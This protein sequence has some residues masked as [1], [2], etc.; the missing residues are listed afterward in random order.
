MRVNSSLSV[1]KGRAVR[2]IRK[3]RIDSSEGAVV[4]GLRKMVST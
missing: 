3:K 1:S 4:I 2:T